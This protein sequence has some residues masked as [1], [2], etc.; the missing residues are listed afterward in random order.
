M[1]GSQEKSHI[2][3]LRLEAKAVCVTV[4]LEQDVPCVILKYMDENACLSSHK[5]AVF[6]PPPHGVFGKFGNLLNILNM[7]CVFHFVIMPSRKEK[8]L[9]ART[10]CLWLVFFPGNTSIGEYMLMAKRGVILT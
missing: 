9:F 6:F 7:R 2:L 8:S 5:G 3:L 10:T 4:Q 1:K